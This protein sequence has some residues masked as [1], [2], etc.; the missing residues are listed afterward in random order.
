MSALSSWFVWTVS[1]M[2]EEEEEEE[3]FHMLQHSQHDSIS[4]SMTLKLQKEQ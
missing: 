1:V 3:K 2:Q 4:M